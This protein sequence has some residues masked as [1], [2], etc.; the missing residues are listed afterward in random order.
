LR[1]RFFK[2]GRI[3]TSQKPN[4]G[5]HKSLSKIFELKFGTRVQLETRK[6]MNNKM[7]LKWGIPLSN[8]IINMFSVKEQMKRSLEKNEVIPF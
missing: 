7:L 6:Q 2:G 1:T 3:V 8:Y 4:F 5:I